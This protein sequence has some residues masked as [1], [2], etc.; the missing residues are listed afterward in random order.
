MKNQLFMA[1]VRYPRQDVAPAV[2][3][4]GTCEFCAFRRTPLSHR[5]VDGCRPLVHAFG[6]GVG[7]DHAARR[8]RSSVYV[9]LVDAVV[10]S[11]AL[12]ELFLKRRPLARI[13]RECEEIG[14][15]KKP[16]LLQTC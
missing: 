14:R 1:G 5:R 13:I 4:S 12:L 16:P 6:I 3:H 8:R 10:R 7:D 11:H 9:L 15:Q 2:G